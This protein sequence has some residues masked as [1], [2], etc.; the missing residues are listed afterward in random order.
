VAWGHRNILAL[1]PSTIEITKSMKLTRRGTCI[2]GVGATMA[3]VDLNEEFKTL[4]RNN[5][6]KITVSLSVGDLEEVIT[7]YGDPRLTF[8]HPEDI[9]LR[10]SQ[11]T[12]DRT[13]CIKADKAA[14]DLSREL[15]GLLRNPNQRMIVSIS[16]E[17]CNR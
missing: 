14:R 13:L 10:R 2:V 1:H 11:Y 6:S 8:M 5:R 15:I 3:V 12:C 17:K 7:G 9:V 16:V 4:A